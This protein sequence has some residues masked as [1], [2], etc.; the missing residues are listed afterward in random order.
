MKQARA[1]LQKRELDAELKRLQAALA[2]V[3]VPAVTPLVTPSTISP[4]SSIEHVFT[5]VSE[6]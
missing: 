1:E 2:V 5:V 3:D 4:P 6:P